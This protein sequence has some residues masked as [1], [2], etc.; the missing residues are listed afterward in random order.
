MGEKPVG[1]S[2]A[3]WLGVLQIVASI[4][5]YAFDLV[6]NDT[7]TWALLLTGII[8]I[9]G[10]WLGGLTVPGMDALQLRAQNRDGWARGTALLLMGVLAIACATLVTR[11]RADMPV[12]PYMNVLVSDDSIHVRLRWKPVLDRRGNAVA[13]YEWEI[14][15]GQTTIGSGQTSDT[16]AVAS[17]PKEPGAE[18]SFAGRV[19]AVDVFGTP[20][21]IATA[22]P[23]PVSVPLPPGPPAP[24]VQIDTITNAAIGVQDLSIIRCGDTWCNVAWTNPL[25][26]LASY[27]VM[28]AASEPAQLIRHPEVDPTVPLLEMHAQGVF[29]DTVLWY[30][31]LDGSTQVDGQLG[32]AVVGRGTCAY[33]VWVPPGERIVC[34]I[35]DLRPE[36]PYN[37]MVARNLVMAEG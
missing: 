27:S 23:I 5:E 32:V 21:D 36:W 1:R 13:H 19:R 12:A 18:H 15:D 7:F 31:T 6:Q 2:K 34:R 28:I 20:G 9:L 26:E 8:T 14:L 35:D 4:A 33:P 11:A 17:V 30:V 22:G 10:R 24:D 25:D 37:V 29:P 16:V 3:I